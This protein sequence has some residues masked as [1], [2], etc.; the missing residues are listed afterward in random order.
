MV[1]NCAAYTQVDAA[2][3]NPQ[4][5]ANVNVLGV[6]NLVQ[7]AEKLGFSIVHFSTDYVFDGKQ[8]TPMPKLPQPRP[9]V[10]MDR[11]S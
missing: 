10:C 1:I 6:E 2:E 7:V 9:W 11:P 8:T 5:A 4:Q 3:A